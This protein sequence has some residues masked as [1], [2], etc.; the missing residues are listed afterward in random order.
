NLAHVRELMSWLEAG[1]LKPN[2][3]ARYG[4]EDAPKALDAMM[5]RE[6]RGKVV[7]VP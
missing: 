7:L 2:I 4:L 3:H 1:K 5:N 6:V